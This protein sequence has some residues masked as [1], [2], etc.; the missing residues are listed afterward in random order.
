VEAFEREGAILDTRGGE[1]PGMSPERADRPDTGVVS[2]TA[3]A[4]DEVADA[5]IR[6]SRTVFAIAVQSLTAT[7]EGVTLPQYR[8]LVTLTYGGRRR[9]ADLACSL[10]VS[11]S[12]ATRMCDRLVRKGL[13]TRT[14]DDIDRREVNLDVTTDGRKIVR[15]VIERRRDEMHYLLKPI[16]RATRNELVEALN[17]LADTSN[18]TSEV[19]WSLGWHE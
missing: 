8:T 14:R 13:I 19:H 18:G 1:I 12:T 15:S 10:G 4:D 9:L 5:I 17:M 3:V 2:R 6:A 7:D 16:P 11:P